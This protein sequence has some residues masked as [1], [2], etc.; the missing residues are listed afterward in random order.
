[1]VYLDWVFV[2]RHDPS[3][4][5]NK[6]YKGQSHVHQYLFNNYVGVPANVS[7]SKQ[8]NPVC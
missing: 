7:R 2:H 3:F 4:V 5:V 1:M 6:Q 8:S